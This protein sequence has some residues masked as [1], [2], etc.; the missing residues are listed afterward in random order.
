MILGSWGSE[1]VWELQERVLRPQQQRWSNSVFWACPPVTQTIP[2]S[3]GHHHISMSWSL[4]TS[5]LYLSGIIAIAFVHQFH[6]SS[7]P[8][9][10]HLYS[11]ENVKFLANH[12]KAVITFPL[13]RSIYQI[14]FTVTIAYSSTFH[15]C[16]QLCLISYIPWTSNKFASLSHYSSLR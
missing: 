9:Y 11:K 4:C 16:I 1:N 2:G 15:I 12:S 7:E 3:C 13:A 6:V 5:L 14:T 8:S 10:Y